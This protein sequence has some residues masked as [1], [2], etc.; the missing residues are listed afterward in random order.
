MG[1]VVVKYALVFALLVCLVGGAYYSGYTS[2]K[3]DTKI[4]Y[5]EKKVVEYVETDKKKA[6]IYSK[7]NATREQ[8][9]GLMK[10]NM[11]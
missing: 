2:G 4:E 3:S 7:P 8:I 5:I 6:A 9:L 1:A 10:N 11:L